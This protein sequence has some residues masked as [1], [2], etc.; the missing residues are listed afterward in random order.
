MLEALVPALPRATTTINTKGDY[1]V[2]HKTRTMPNASRQLSL[3]L[4]KDPKTE[5]TVILIKVGDFT[6]I[7]LTLD[8]SRAL[9]ESLTRMRNLHIEHLQHQVERARINAKVPNK[10][11]EV[12]SGH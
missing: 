10:T 7:T 11:R 9:V 2:K 3:A 5:E 12:E 4:D 8:Q 1:E 6:E